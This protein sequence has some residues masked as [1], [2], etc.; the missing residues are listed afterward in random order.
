M[1]K[2]NWDELNRFIKNDCSQV[3]SYGFNSYDFAVENWKIGTAADINVSEL[4]SKTK[5][6]AVQIAD[7]YAVPLEQNAKMYIRMA[8]LRKEIDDFLREKNK[9]IEKTRARF[10]I[11][12]EDLR[13]KWI[14]TIKLERQIELFEKI[15]NLITVSPIVYSKIEHGNHKEAVQ[16]IREA[17]ETYDD[18]RFEAIESLDTVKENIDKARSDMIDHVINQLFSLLFVSNRPFGISFY[19]TNSQ[20]EIRIPHID[21]S[22]VEEYTG[23]LVSLNIQNDFINTFRETVR[24]RLAQM[25]S[26]TADSIKVTKIRQFVQNKDGFEELVDIANNYNIHHPL[27]MFIDQLLSKMWVLLT[28]CKAFD[29]VFSTDKSISVAFTHAHSAIDELLRDII[30]SFTS[31]QGSKTLNVTSQL[32]F[33]FLMSD[34]TPSNGTASAL[35]HELGIKPCSANSLHMFMMIDDFRQAAKEKYGVDSTALTSRISIDLDIQKIFNDQ[36][37]LISE[38][39]DVSR[40][41]KTEMHPVPVLI[42]TPFL[43]ESMEKYT[44]IAARFPYLQKIV[45]TGLLTFLRAFKSRCMKEIGHTK[46]VETQAQILSTRLLNSDKDLILRYSAQFI[47]QELVIK[48]SSADCQSHVGELAALEAQ[49]ESEL[50]DKFSPLSIENTVREKFCLPTMAAIAES[51]VVIRNTLYDL[52]QRYNFMEQIGAEI[53]SFAEDLNMTL[54]RAMVFIR[55]EMRC[56]AYAEIVQPLLNG[57]YTPIA[58]PVRPEQYVADFISTYKS[59]SENISPCLTPSRFGFVFIGLPRLVNEIHIKYVPRVREISDKGAAQLTMNLSALNQSLSISQYPDTSTY[60]KALVFVSNISYSTDRILMQIA[61]QKDLFT[62]E[63]MEPVFN[64]QQKM[65]ERHAENLEKLKQLLQK[66]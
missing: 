25:M 20:Q 19:K 50:I 43:V 59:S 6:F 65:N 51:I 31:A 1:K 57:N 17:I 40:P 55:I 38:G 12:P 18:L 33:K 28:S 23:L 47:T 48:D 46:S 53:K 37:K 63:E 22:K 35:R 5:Q 52:L 14:K 49:Y 3:I 44:A 2:V 21:T 30:T 39:I 36:T 61:Q 4:L 13:T 11:D 56:R 58:S 66:K 32:S 34:S 26:E 62:Y 24:D 9:V 10:T 29:E 42:S 27:V 7:E 15:E 8:E 41:V 60:K 45:V 16:H 64:M 54:V